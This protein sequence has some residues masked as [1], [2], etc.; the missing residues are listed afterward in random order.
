MTK[1]NKY[2]FDIFTKIDVPDY[3]RAILCNDQKNSM[4][5]W[6]DMS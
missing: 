5:R 6:H 3:L 4:T 1:N 2:V